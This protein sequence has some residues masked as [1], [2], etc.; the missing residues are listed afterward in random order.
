MPAIVD[1]VL[2]VNGNNQVIWVGHSMGSM[3][4]FAAMHHRGEELGA[5]VSII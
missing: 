1:K 4:M 5:K 2:E 3:M